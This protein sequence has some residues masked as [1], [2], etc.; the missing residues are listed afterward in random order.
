MCVIVAELADQVVNNASLDAGKPQ[1]PLGEAVLN[2][3][4]CALT[5]DEDDPLDVNTEEHNASLP[6]WKKVDLM[7]HQ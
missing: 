5:V 4:Q 7:P 6:D 1:Q 3:L 2:D